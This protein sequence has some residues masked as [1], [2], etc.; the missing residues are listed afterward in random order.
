[1]RLFLLFSIILPVMAAC[2]S[3]GGGISGSPTDAG[4]APAKAEYHK[5]SQQDAK[6]IMDSGEAY[7]LVDVR[8]QSEYDTGHINGAV[9]IPVDEIGARAAS[10]LP[11]KNAL[12]MVYCRSG[13]RS[14]Q[15]ATT[16]V[17]LGYTNV[18]DIGGISTWPYDNVTK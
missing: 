12:I 10:E 18:Q 15:A 5:M 1:M 13:V 3:Q 8:T 9:L 14:S 16:L 7:T 2:A 11:D 17:G 4:T 6:K